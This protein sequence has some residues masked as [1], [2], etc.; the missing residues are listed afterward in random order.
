MDR[1]PAAFNII[2]FLL[3]CGIAEK[4]LAQE[5]DPDTLGWQTNLTGKLAASQAGYQNWA[6]GGINTL[7]FTVA[8]NGRAHRVA[9]RWQQKHESRLAYGLV[10]QDTLDFRKADDLISLV[11][12]LQYQGDGFFNT[13]NPTVAAS[14]RTQ[15]APGF[16]YD[17]DPFNDSLMRELPVKVS[18][19]LSPATFTQSIGLTYDPKPWI[20]QRL[21]LAVKETV[22]G[23]ER[24]RPLYGLDLDQAARVEAG[25]ESRTAFD[26][27]ILPNVQL[28]STLGLFAA[29]NQ[30][31]SPDMIWENLVVMQVNKYLSV[32][33]EFVTLYDKDVREDLQLKEVLSLG[34]SVVLL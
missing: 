1:F 8:T 16:N 21:G 11:S 25:L 32:N 15:F 20:T 3:L 29:F 26:R 9:G 18:D 17:K 27:E 10:K 33:F 13:F 6:E 5:A 34:V 7:A 19:F 22:V 2:L 12:S 23:I 28:Q 30:V 31:G 4:T 14:A 24:L